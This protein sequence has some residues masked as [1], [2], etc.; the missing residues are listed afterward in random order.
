[1]TDL[2]L[3]PS[4]ANEYAVIDRDWIV[5]HIVLLSPAMA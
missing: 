1:M 3:Q 4:G 5:G 2:L